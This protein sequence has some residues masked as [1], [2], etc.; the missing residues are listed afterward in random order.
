[1]ARAK[2][3]VGMLGAGNGVQ[4]Q[5]S[6]PAGGRII[7]VALIVAA[8]LFMENL[9]GT[10]IVTALPQM[11]RSFGVVPTRMSLGVTAYMLTLAAGIPASA[12]L[13]SRVGARNLFCMAI[14]A[15]TL[16]SM[17]CG[18]A[19]SFLIFILARV[20]QGAAAS[21]MTPV[22]RAIVLRGA[23]KTNM[24]RALSTQVWP[25]LFAPVLGP[26]LGGLITQ[27]ASW[28]WIFYVNLPLGLIG[29]AL[30]LAYI[31]KEAREP[32]T[33]FDTRGFLL[34]AGA[35]AALTY[36]LD[37]LGSV[38]G[39]ASAALWQGLALT[40]TSVVLGAMVVR[41]ARRAAHPVLDFTTLRVPTFFV[42]VVSGG[43]LTRA[44][45]HATP[46]LLPLMFQLGFGLTPL[47]SGGLVLIYMAGNL[48]MKTMTNPLMTR[49]GIRNVLLV[50]AVLVAVTIASCALIAPR[51]PLAWSGAILFAAGLS[52]SMQFTA[53]LMVS[54]ADVPQP[55]RAPATALFSLSQTLSMGLGVVT[56]ALML[57][58]TQGLRGAATLDLFDFRLA[59]VLIGA[60]SLV[61]LGSYLKLPKDAGAEVS[62]HRV[63]AARR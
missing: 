35:L 12:W 22:G 30:V 40:A 58:L 38:R 9:D 47:E 36:G 18:A 63:A 46:F 49:F 62:G 45:L 39:A 19:P 55:Q 59:F 54:F 41:H 28:R 56:G 21:M 48:V 20:C 17:L 24:M 13:A 8:A 15:F 1:M 37:R 14:G 32:R 10:I 57:N 16:S 33:P 7:V 52:R 6:S 2:G 3:N 25:S 31:P 43:T 44:A 27:L 53:L 61:I 51:G 11:A 4:D 29:M 34:M 42:S 5:A 50:N 23:D 60:G 26:P